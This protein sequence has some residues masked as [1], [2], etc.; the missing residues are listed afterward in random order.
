MFKKLEK[1]LLIQLNDAQG[2]QHLKLKFKQI[3]SN[4]ITV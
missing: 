4:E 1:N 2:W 3:N